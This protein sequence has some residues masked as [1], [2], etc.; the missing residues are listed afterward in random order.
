MRALLT[1]TLHSRGS[2]WKAMT[3]CAFSSLPLLLLP[4]L[5]LLLRLRLPRLPRLL[6]YVPSYL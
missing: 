3:A 6:F 5:Q 2:A 4:L 1:T